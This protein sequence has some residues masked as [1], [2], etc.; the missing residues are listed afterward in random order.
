MNL[1]EGYV[2][3]HHAAPSTLIIGLKI[4]PKNVGV[5]EMQAAVARGGLMESMP[6]DQSLEKGVKEG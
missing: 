4:F 3:V 2:G 6:F 1:D 5:K